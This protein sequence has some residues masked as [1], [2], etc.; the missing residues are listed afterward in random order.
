[1]FYCTLCETF[2]SA[3]PTQESEASAADHWLDEHYPA[4]GTL[5]PFAV[6]AF[7]WPDVLLPEATITL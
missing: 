5:R 3:D 4:E 7:E 1:M 2:I 6:D